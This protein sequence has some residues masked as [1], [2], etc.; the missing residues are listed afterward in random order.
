MNNIFFLIWQTIPG[1]LFSYNFILSLYVGSSHDDLA[2]N[3]Y[4]KI[5]YS[6]KNS[7]NGNNVN[8]EIT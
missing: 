6:K 3:S 2:Q 1:F 4:S 8:F 5:L 7:H